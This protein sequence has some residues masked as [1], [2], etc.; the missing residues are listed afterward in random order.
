MQQSRKTG[1]RL[2]VAQRQLNLKRS[3]NQKSG[4][5]KILAN[6]DNQHDHDLAIGRRFKLRLPPFSS[7]LSRNNADRLEAN[8]DGGAERKR[9]VRTKSRL[10]RAE[11][12]A[13][14]SLVKWRCPGRSLLHRRSRNCSR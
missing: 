12:N 6:Y 7:R 5:K 9:Q 8:R 4:A 14:G 2:I 13:S 1:K 3:D 10:G 11:A